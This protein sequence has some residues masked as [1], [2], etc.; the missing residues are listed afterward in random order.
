MSLGFS[1][2]L[3]F[4]TVFLSASPPADGFCMEASFQGAPGT[5]IQAKPVYFFHRHILQQWVL[6]GVTFALPKGFLAISEKVFLLS[7]LGL[8]TGIYQE[9]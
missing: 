9:C 2:S 5:Q 3:S 7:R 6:T 4:L 1:P 8:V